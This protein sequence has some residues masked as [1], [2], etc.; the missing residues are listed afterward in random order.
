M[1]REKRKERAR[2]EKVARVKITALTIFGAELR[3]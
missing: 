3:L 2:R 1:T